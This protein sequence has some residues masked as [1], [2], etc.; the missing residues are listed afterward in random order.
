MKAILTLLVVLVVPVAI[1]FFAG[2]AKGGVQ[3][4]GS[5]VLKFAKYGAIFL[6]ACILLM[7]VLEAV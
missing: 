4:G 3:E 7:L 5:Q 6:G 2:V 1:I